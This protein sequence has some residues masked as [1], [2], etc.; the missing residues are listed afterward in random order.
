MF[1]DFVP[2]YYHCSF[3]FIITTEDNVSL[4]E[5]RCCE[6][7]LSSLGSAHVHLA[8]VLLLQAWIS[9][10]GCAVCKLYEQNKENLSGIILVHPEMSCSKGLRAGFVRM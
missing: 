6:V 3:R 4:W 5:R 10:S 8:T 2:G 1:T 7:T 9:A